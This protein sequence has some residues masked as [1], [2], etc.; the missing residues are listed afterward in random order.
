MVPP[1][2]QVT[3]DGYDLQ[4]GTNCLGSYFRCFGLSFSLSDACYDLGH[5]YFTRLLLPTL[6]E[7]A[8]ATPDQ[9]VRVVTTSS[10]THMFHGINWDTLRDGPA[11]KK[12][13]TSN[14]YSQSK[15]VSNP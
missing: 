9:K 13:G 12:L 11:R 10:S 6:V 3:A 4:F 15:F 1:V 5:F 7:T 14:L 8:K 2:E